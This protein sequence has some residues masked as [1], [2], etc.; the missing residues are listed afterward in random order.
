VLLYQ[1]R[2]T[3]GPPHILDRATARPSGLTPLLTNNNHTVRRVLVR[4]PTQQGT[5]CGHDSAKKGRGND[6][7]DE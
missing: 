2:R 6:N 1:R 7:D 3:C 4:G 5:G